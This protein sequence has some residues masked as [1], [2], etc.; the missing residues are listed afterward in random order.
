MTFTD[1][2]LKALGAW[3]KGWNEDQSKKAELEIE[4]KSTTE[5][6]P[7]KYKSVS[8]PCYRKRFLHKG[9]LYEIIMVDEKDE[10]VTSWTIDKR[11]AE[12]F[13]GVYK[14][15]AVS[16]AIFE[17]SPTSEEVI[18][19]IC[20]LWKCEQ[21]TLAVQNYTE[22][23]GEHSD[24]LN[25]FKATQGEVILS[26]PLK[27]S[28]IIALTGAAS[29]FDELCEQAGIEEEKRDDYYRQLV[30]QDIYPDE[31]QYT[32]KEGTQRVIQKTIK[33]MDALI[34]SVMGKDI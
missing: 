21:F 31:I 17:H 3:Q 2:F 12:R 4:L 26:S 22:R 18:V 8:T 13:K 29:P 34:Q 23:L 6:L 14:A 28:E 19:N 9:E 33:R 5:H 11:Y 24:A 30:E 25:N 10:G 20:E 27:G 7:K 15:N 32:T 1:D 16:G